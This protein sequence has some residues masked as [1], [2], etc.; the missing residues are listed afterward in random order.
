MDKFLSSF[1]LFSDIPWG[2]VVCWILLLT[3]VFYLTCH[4]VM[5][6]ISCVQKSGTIKVY[7]IGFFTAA[8][9]LLAHLV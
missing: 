4:I 9:V 1:T 6:I 2:S 7:H 5:L 3:C 8:I